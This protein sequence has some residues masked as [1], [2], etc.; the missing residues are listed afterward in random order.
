MSKTTITIT[1]L[2]M[3]DLGNIKISGVDENNNQVKDENYEKEKET[4]KET[5]D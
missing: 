2:S 4:E 3:D 5:E 1:D